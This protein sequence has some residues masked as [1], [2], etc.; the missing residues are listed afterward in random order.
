MKEYVLETT[1]IPYGWSTTNAGI[2]RQ[3]EC[4]KLFQRHVF[5]EFVNKLKGLDFFF[6]Q[7]RAKI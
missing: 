2:C 3:V 4:G 5:K 6:P 1:V 7:D